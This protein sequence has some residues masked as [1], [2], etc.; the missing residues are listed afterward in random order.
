MITLQNSIKL[1]WLHCFT[2]EELDLN[3][4]NVVFQASSRG[5]SE[6]VLADVCPSMPIFDISS[7]IQD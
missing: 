7:F 1:W 6:K 3:L 2:F 5:G 4:F